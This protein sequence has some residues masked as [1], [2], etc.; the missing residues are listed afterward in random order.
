VTR[1]VAIIGTGLMGGSIGLALRKAGGVHVVGVDAS[2]EHARDAL[3]AGALDEIADD[4]GTAAANAELIVVATPVGEILR[5]IEAVAATARDGTVVTDIGSTKQT[6]VAAAERILGPDRAFVGGHPM[7]GTEGEGIASARPDLFDGAL[8]FL[9]PT[10]QT[11]SEAYRTVNT[12][13]SSIGARTL[14]LEPSEHD[15][16]VAL[17]SHLPYAI[18]TALMG[19]AAQ[20]DDDRLYRAA[21]GSFRDVTRTAGSNPRIWR[22]IFATNAGAVAAEL[23][24][25]IAQLTELR[26]AVVGGNWDSFDDLVTRARDARRRLPAKGERAVVDPVT[27]EVAIADRA[28]AL[29][30]V[31][32]TF[33]EGG[34]NIEDLWV[35]HT[36][37]GGV[38]RILVD[39]EAAATR[40]AELLAGRG[41]HATVV[42]DA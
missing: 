16:L 39:G 35:D 5:T 21:A 19:L 37:S 32:T 3:H 41:Y 4:P 9:T 33:G 24:G 20:G 27:V 7:A 34:I 2:A 14:A 11:S 18:A 22:D 1:R 30:E 12:L 6:I 42:K 15:R 29:A 28:G 10:S 40:A 13:V 25:F 23:D 17:V 31:T 8:W 38:L 26:D 36:A